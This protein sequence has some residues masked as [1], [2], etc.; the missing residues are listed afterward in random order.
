MLYGNGPKNGSARSRNK[1]SSAEI[2]GRRGGGGDDAKMKVA[3]L[4][5]VLAI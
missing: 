5:L 3:D 4:R 2:S 1:A